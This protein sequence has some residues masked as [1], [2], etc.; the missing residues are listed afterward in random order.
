MHATAHAQPSFEPPAGMP[1]LR[2]ELL[3][4][5]EPVI[6]DCIN[7][8]YGELQPDAGQ[9]RFLSAQHRRLWRAILL[10]HRG[11]MGSLYSELR[12]ELGAA[13]LATDVAETIDQSVF[14]ELVDIVVKRYRTSNDKAKRCSMILLDAASF[15]GASRGHA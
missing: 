6:A 7:G 11:I 13:G 1:D 14:E 12:D 2:R 15:I 4:L 9:A 3:N 10:Q 8:A 5:A